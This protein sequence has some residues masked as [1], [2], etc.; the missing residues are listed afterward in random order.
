M[1]KIG[2]EILEGQGEFVEKLK[3]NEKLHL[4]K[5]NDY[6]GTVHYSDE[7]HLFYGKL[8]F[9]RGL[10]SYESAD[11]KSLYNLDLFTSSRA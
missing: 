7:D 5:Y 9:I 1:S 8:A 3:T 2:K 10:I 11:V 4:M 6:Y